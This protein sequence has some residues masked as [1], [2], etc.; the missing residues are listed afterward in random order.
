VQACRKLLAMVRGVR[1]LWIMVLVLALPLQGTAAATMRLCG[2]GQPAGHDHATMAMAMAT[3][4]A[5]AAADDASIHAGHAMPAADAAGYSDAQAKC[6]A[7]AVCCSALALLAQPLKLACVPV[8]PS[9]GA[10]PSAPEMSFDP[11]GL[12]RPPRQRIPA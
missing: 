4:P 3:A 2:S 10:G 9:Y 5:D 12:E 8:P 6:S 7:C 11:E 1:W